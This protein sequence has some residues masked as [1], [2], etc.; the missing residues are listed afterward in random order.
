MA[1]ANSFTC[2]FQDCGRVFYRALELKKHEIS[3]TNPEKIFACPTCPFITLQKRG[4][5]IHMSQHT[6]ERRFHCPHPTVSPQSSHS[7]GSSGSSSGG[8]GCEFKT[9][10]PAAL[11]RHRKACHGYVPLARGRASRNGPRDSPRAA[12]TQASNS[13]SRSSASGRHRSFLGPAGS[14][15]ESTDS[16]YSTAEPLSWHGNSS[17]STEWSSD[18]SRVAQGLKRGDPYFGSEWDTGYVED[19]SASYLTEIERIRPDLEMEIHEEDI[20]DRRTGR[21]WCHCPEW[22]IE[23]RV[24]GW[25]ESVLEANKEYYKRLLDA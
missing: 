9:G 18:A 23:S 2:S 11:T 12:A 15:G 7:G 24:E 21:E 20:F 17:D 1:P 19:Y 8:M 16:G 6:G 4:L 10:D 25:D 13:T 22:M 3:H 5:S 14:S